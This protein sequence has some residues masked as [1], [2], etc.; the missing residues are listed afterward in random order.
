MLASRHSDA[1]SRHQS[2]GE[3]RRPRLRCAA[4]RHD[5][6]AQGARLGAGCR[7]GFRRGFG[8]KTAPEGPLAGLCT[9]RNC[10]TTR[11]S[12]FHPLW[13]VNPGLSTPPIPK[14]TLPVQPAHAGILAVFLTGSHAF[15]TLRRTPPEIPAMLGALA[16]AVF[17]GHAHATM[18]R[19]RAE[20]A[21]A[22]GF[23]AVGVGFATASAQDDQRRQDSH[24][25]RGA[26]SRTHA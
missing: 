7:L 26:C 21:A 16:L 19:A 3:R 13:V 11:N 24:Q 20:H 14:P 18:G 25:A 22:H 5:G 2:E 6:G 12:Y 4:Q 9:T 10:A 1:V 15:A 17:R 23:A 8:W